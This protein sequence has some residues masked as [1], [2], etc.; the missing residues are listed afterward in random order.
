MYERSERI[1]IVL[2]SHK[3]VHVNDSEFF[4][5]FQSYLKDFPKASPREYGPATSRFT[6]KEAVQQGARIYGDTND[7]FPRWSSECR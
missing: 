6:S 1:A 4:I 5:L 2:G 7:S 3:L